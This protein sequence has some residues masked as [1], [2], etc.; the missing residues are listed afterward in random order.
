VPRGDSLLR[1]DIEGRACFKENSSLHIS[2]AKFPNELFSQK[3]SIYPAKFP[4]DLFSVIYTYE[5]QLFISATGQT[6]IT[7]PTALSSL[8]ISCH[9]CTFCASLH[10]KTSPDRR[11]NEGKETRRRPRKMIPDSMMADGYGKLREKAQQ[12]DEWRRCTLGPAY[13]RKRLSPLL[14]NPNMF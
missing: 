12:R 2:S 1:T 11:K 9:H 8:H 10:V 5:C 7:A 13:I 6:I 14:I 4:N 3:N